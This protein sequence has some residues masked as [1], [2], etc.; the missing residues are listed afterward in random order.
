[1]PVNTPLASSTPRSRWKPCRS[2]AT[3]ST[4]TGTT[5]SGQNPTKRP[6]QPGSRRHAD[7]R[8]ELFIF[9]CLAR[10]WKQFATGK[11]WPDD[12]AERGDRHD[13]VHGAVLA[14]LALDF[15]TGRFLGGRGTAWHRRARWP[16]PQRRVRRLLLRAGERV[17][18][19]PGRPGPRMCW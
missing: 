13:L 11:G 4:R 5:P 10:V 18:L 9:D 15:L 7:G 1:I 16:R 14:V 6:Y 3:A 17:R 2:T 19:D 8:P 12:H